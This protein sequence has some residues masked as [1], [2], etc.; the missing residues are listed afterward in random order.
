MFHPCLYLICKKMVLSFFPWKGVV[1]HEEKATS[2]SMWDRDTTND[3]KNAVWNFV[4]KYETGIRLAA[5]SVWSNSVNCSVSVMSQVPKALANQ[6]I[7]KKPVQRQADF[8]AVLGSKLSCC[9]SMKNHKNTGTC[10]LK[11]IGPVFLWICSSTC[12]FLHDCRQK[13]IEGLSWDEG[14]DERK[15]KPFLV[16]TRRASLEVQLIMSKWVKRQC[17]SVIAFQCIL[18]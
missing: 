5:P 17:L 18:F 14:S 1:S 10:M 16:N 11:H 7:F 15:A 12:N 4:A 9:I 6:S 8:K 2:W 3:H 13:G